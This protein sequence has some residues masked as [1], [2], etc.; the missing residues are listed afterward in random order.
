MK[1]ELCDDILESVNDLKKHM[2]S[3]PFKHASFKHV[4]C[5]F[6]GG[7]K[8]TMEVHLG[9]YHSENFECALCDHKDKS[10]E[11]LETHLFTCE[12]LLCDDCKM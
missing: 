3:H 10:L 6:V 7:S 9:K 5:D 8:E 1:C 2:K 11:N 12:I 4:E